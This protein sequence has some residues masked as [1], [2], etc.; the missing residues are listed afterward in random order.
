MQIFWKKKCP[1]EKKYIPLHRIFKENSLFFQAFLRKP[2]IIT[3]NKQI[4]FF[5]NKLSL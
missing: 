5:K 4:K 2:H 3:F 1:F